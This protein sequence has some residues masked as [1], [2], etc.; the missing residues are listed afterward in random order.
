MDKLLNDKES[1]TDK[2]NTLIKLMNEGIIITDSVGRIY[3]TNEKA[4]KLLAERSKV[5]QGFHIQEVLPELDLDCLLYTSQR[6][7]VYEQVCRV[8]FLFD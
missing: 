7:Q 3:L 5:L 8:R 2:L 1:M 4:Q 6:S